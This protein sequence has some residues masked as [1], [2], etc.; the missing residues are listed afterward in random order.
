MP[1]RPRLLLSS[2]ALV[3]AAG[4]AQVTVTPPSASTASNPSSSPTASP[5]ASSPSASSPT[6]TASAIP[7]GRDAPTAD[8]EQPTLPRGG[9]EIFP[10]YRLVGYAGLTGASTLGRLGT[11]P[12][13][14]RVRE[15]ERRAEAYEA[16]RKVLPVLEVIATIVQSGPGSDGK[17]RTRVSD[18]NIAVY[19]AAARKRKALLLLNIQPG[20][21]EFLPEAKAYE[22]WLREP[23]VGVALDPEWAMDPGQRPGRAYGHTTGAE[24]NQT[25]AYLANLVRRHDLPEKVMVYHQVAASVVRKESGLKPHP[26]VV[27]IKSVDGLGPP[28]PKVNTYR[29]VNKTTPKHVH[30][31]FKL[32]FTEDTEGASRLM[33]PREVLGLKPRPEYVM[34]E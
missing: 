5:S 18:K 12:L 21:S 14:Q 27:Q 30:A 11:G 34:Y 7:S 4:C 25:A 22:R 1:D 26:G 31:G 28:G 19:L 8:A 3:L 10:T 32:F 20:R 9:R 33:T 29:V 6:P 15:L 13:D 16:G 17:Y 23:D 24:L 2:V